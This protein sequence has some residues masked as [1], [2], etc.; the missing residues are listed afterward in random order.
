[1]AAVR[2]SELVAIGFI[3]DEIIT[4]VTSE[5]VSNKEI[6]SYQAVSMTIII[7]PSIQQNKRT[8]ILLQYYVICGP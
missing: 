1:M 6:V 8:A 2:Y 5:Q 3:F 4:G 7:T